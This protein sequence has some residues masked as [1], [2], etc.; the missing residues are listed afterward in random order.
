MNLALEEVDC[1]PLP[2]VNQLAE[3]TVMLCQPPRRSSVP[4][5]VGSGVLLQIEHHR[6]LLTASHVFDHAAPSSSVYAIAAMEFV[7]LGHRWRTT[8]NG[9]T[10]GR[11][12]RDLGIVPLGQESPDAW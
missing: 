2:M 1:R 8:A 4:Q 9:R 3:A 7:A 5:P 11:D 10:G 6:F 12:R